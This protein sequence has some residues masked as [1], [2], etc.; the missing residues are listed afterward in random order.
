MNCHHMPGMVICYG[1][2][3]LTDREQKNA[4]IGQI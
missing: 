3:I 4:Y 1:M 2:Q